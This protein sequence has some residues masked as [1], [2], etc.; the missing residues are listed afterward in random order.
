MAP[1]KGIYRRYDG[2]LCLVVGVALHHATD[3]YV[4]RYVP[5]YG[6]CLEKVESA[7]SFFSLLFDPS[8]ENPKPKYQYLYSEDPKWYLNL[9]K[10][11]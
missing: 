6:D 3:E 1:K 8:I 5:L 11:E 7:T 2:A 4:I 9:D 10:L